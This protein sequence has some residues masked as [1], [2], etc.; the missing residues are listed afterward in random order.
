MGRKN[1]IEDKPR[2]GR[3]AIYGQ[4]ERLAITGFYCQTKPF[5]ESGRW[6]LRFASQYLRMYPNI[7]GISV[8]K[9]SIHRILVENN[10][11]PHRSKYFF[12]YL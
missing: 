1:T 11:K 7:I 4:S 12:T 2:S 5:E 6:T 8:S 9:S 3:S 10:L